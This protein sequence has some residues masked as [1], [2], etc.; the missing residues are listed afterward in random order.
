MTMSSR[1]SPHRAVRL[2]ALAALALAATPALASHGEHHSGPFAGPKAD[3]GS[4]THAVEEG[5]HVL[6]LSDD[7]KTPE[8]PDP[9]WQLVD[10][11]GTT[12]LLDRLTV[13]PDQT[14]RR[15]IVVPSYVRDVAKVQMWCAWAEVVLGEAS[16]PRPIA[17]AGKAAAVANR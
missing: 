6:I 16:F 9:H 12:Y 5:R 3:R 1:S 13:K 11:K 17:I 4:V 2:A 15:R 14:L 10:S 8:A 7:F